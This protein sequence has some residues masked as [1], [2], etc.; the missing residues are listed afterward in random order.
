M[1]WLAILGVMFGFYYY[2]LTHMT[3]TVL[4]QLQNIQNQYSYVADHADQIA[5]GR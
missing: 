1:R 2:F 5:T 3:N 4:T